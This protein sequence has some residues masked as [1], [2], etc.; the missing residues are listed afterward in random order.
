MRRDNYEG[1]FALAIET[2]ELAILAIRVTPH[3]LVF[4]AQE[5]TDDIH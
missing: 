2:G 1:Y 5:R 4:P 3:L